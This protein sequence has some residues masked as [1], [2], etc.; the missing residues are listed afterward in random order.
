VDLV[1][2]VGALG[3]AGRGLAGRGLA[4]LGLAGLGLAG[5]GLAGLGLAGRGMA[6]LGLG[7]GVVAAGFG[8]GREGYLQPLWGTGFSTAVSYPW[9]VSHLRMAAT[10]VV[11]DLLRVIRSRSGVC[12][13]QQQ[14]LSVRHSCMSDLWDLVRLACNTPRQNSMLEFCDPHDDSMLSATCVS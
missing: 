11:S 2:G 6:G 4:G 9:V 5:L 12:T 1:A 7:A 13:R 10:E 8:F 3:L 14:R